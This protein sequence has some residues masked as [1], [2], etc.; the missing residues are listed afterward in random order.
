MEITK[1]QRVVRQVLEFHTETEIDELK[2]LR[3]AGKDTKRRFICVEFDFSG[4]SFE[5][6]ISLALRGLSI[7]SKI[8]RD[9]HPGEDVVESFRKKISEIQAEKTPKSDS[10]GF[11][12][13]WTVEVKDG[14]TGKESAR[15]AFEAVTGWRF[16][17]KKGT[18]TKTQLKE[19]LSG[20]ERL[21]SALKE[22]GKSEEEI[23]AILAG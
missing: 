1:G 6:L 7:S 20:L 15:D 9:D 12:N 8:L 4:T 16:E 2:K 14:K 13:V 23:Q 5:H 21:K 22:Q 19:A 10:G 18:G 11:K 17:K 3:A